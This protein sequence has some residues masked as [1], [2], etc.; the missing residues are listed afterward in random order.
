MFREVRR[1][2]RFEGAMARARGAGIEPWMLV[3]GAIL[4]VALGLRL[5][6]IKY[7]MPFAYQI[8]EERIYVRKAARMLDNGTV[9]PHYQHNPPLLT[10]LLEAIFFVRYGLHHARELIG[11]VPDREQLFLIGRVLVAVIGTAGVWLMFVAGRRFFDRRTGLVAAALMAVAFL[12]VFYSH[13]ALN[14]VPAM[15]ALT[16]ALVGTAGV[17]DRGERRDYVLAGAGLGVAVATKYIEGIALVPL[18]AAVALAPRRPGAEDR[19]RG[20][21]IALGAAAAAFVVLNPFALIKPAHF[22]GS[23]STQES[24]VAVH[25]FGQ[26]AGNALTTYLR[27]FSWGLGW[28]P[29]AA[30]L[31]GAVLL[32]RDDR[33]RAA[34]LLPVLPLFLAYMSIQ[35][36]Y[37]GRWMLPLFPILCLLAAHGAVRLADLARARLRQPPPAGAAAAVAAAV[38]VAQ[39]LVYSIHSDRVLSRPHTQN[40][41]RA[42]MLDH[43]PADAKV[44]SEPLRADG[45]DAPW[46]GTTSPR[47]FLGGES[48]YARYLSPRLV[49]SYI[50]HRYCWVVVSSNYWG[51]ALSDPVISQRA[52]SYYAA[53]QRR[54]TL[55]FSA[56]PW[57][58]I[59]SP[60]G[61][62][63][64]KVA[65]DFDFSYDFYPLAY[66]R[67]GPMVH[68]YELHGGRC[69]RAPA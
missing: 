36:R 46:R 11:T 16:L 31:A 39:G 1:L 51:L 60:G 21:L 48:A 52:A 40:V 32:L 8:D 69:G 4:L 25:K 42:W 15:A 44:A 7:G 59:S 53:L 2:P 5:W 37:F 50:E 57:G 65:F 18:L 12:P 35:T 61:P 49:D 38:L 67:P 47:R 64:D 22:V 14:N 3:L 29:V 27:T 19:G 68:V 55:R 20:L 10:Y 66:D 9:N 34:V 26:D 17:L 63:E 28:V 24:A 23:L 56:S 58:D 6:G 62:G 41:A 33:R 13:V 54:G 45:W 43:V 30:A